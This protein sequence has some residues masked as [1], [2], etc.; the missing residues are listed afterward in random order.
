MQTHHWR[1]LITLLILK[2][3]FIAG[4]SST[5]VTGTWKKSDFVAQPFSSIMVIGLTKDPTNRL[6]WENRMG[7]KLSQGG[8]KT[9]I[10]SL[11]ASPDDRKIDKEVLLDYVNNK[12]VEAVL[13]T[14]LVD[15]KQEQVYNPPS[16]GYINPSASYYLNF[17]N[18]FS[19][20]YTQ[21]YSPGYMTTQT[22]VLLETTLY[23]VKDK[24]LIWSMTSDTVESG[25]VQQL[26]K[27]VTGKV[28][29]SLRKGN[30]I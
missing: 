7:D 29:A 4:C 27:S 19:H 12:G 25:S 21:V 15:T 22:I 14:R 30:L 24:E 23:Q 8:V 1:I 9:V 6:F 28:L 3:F 26:M 10:K 11:S 13:I 17:N 16:A 18:Y 20:A 2:L 5:S